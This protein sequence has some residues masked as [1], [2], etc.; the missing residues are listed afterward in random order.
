MRTRLAAAL[1]VAGLLSACGGGEPAAPEPGARTEVTVGVIPI[2]E[3]AAVYVARDEGFFGEAGLDVTIETANTSSA[4]VPAVV[5]GQYDFGFS[6][7]VTLILGR[8]RG[9][10][11]TAVAA[12]SA[13][14]P[15]GKDD[16]AAVIA[17]DPAIRTAADLA[18]KRVAVNALN[19]IAATS[20]RQAVRKA[21][22]DPDSMQLVELG[23]ADQ[24]AALKAGRIDAGF[25]VEPYLALARREGAH[26]VTYPYLSVD[27]D[28]TVASYMAS[29]GTLK[30]KPEAVRGFQVALRKAAELIAEDRAVLD[31]ALST[32][33]KIDRSVYPEMVPC[34]FPTAVDRGSVDQWVRLMVTDGLLTTEPDLDTLVAQDA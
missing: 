29:G 15:G 13:P 6:N 27:P 22:A 1:A 32:F 33:T 10:D 3:A 21:G 18:G 24:A 25:T 26:V 2:M 34:A 8:S 17:T 7:M 28:V 11:L 16:M 20:L 23:F 30:N 14:A 9:L 31:K 12:A 5:S 19:N 4:I